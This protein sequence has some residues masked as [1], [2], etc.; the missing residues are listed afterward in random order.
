MS[1]YASRKLYS[2]RRRLVAE[3]K[4]LTD[5]E[6]KNPDLL[7]GLQE[8]VERLEVALR[9]D[10]GVYVVEFSDPDVRFSAFEEIPRE[11]PKKTRRFPG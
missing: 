2:L 7:K 11:R 3:L 8:Q 10:I 4:Q 9:N 6:L 5:E 1:S